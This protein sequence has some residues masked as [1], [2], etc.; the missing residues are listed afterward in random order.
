MVFSI[1]NFAF[2]IDRDLARQVATPTAVVTCN[3]SRLREVAAMELT[4][5]VKSFTSTRNAGTL[6]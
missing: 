5:S 1:E 2:D 4:E 3:I 6:A